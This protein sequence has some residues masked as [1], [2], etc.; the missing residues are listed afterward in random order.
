MTRMS[1]P[2][3]ALANRKRNY[4]LL[5]LAVFVLDQWS[6]WWVEANLALH[7]PVEVIPGFLNLTHVENP[8]VAFGLFSGLESPFRTILLTALGLGALTVVGF[9]Y[10]RVDP[11]QR[12]LLAGLSLILGGAVGNLTDR[13]QSGSVTDFVDAY[14][15][16]YH[17]H[18]FNVADS[19]ITI[20][21]GLILLD[22]FRSE[23]D[24]QAAH[25]GENPNEGAVA[26]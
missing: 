15:K 16:S 21:V 25:E 2:D 4:L 19:A 10:A 18:T 11:R 9:Y 14:Y 1:M 26:G 24:A 12:L 6:K 22:S 3:S 17:W 20:A 5:A 7:R 13:I 8:G 23:P